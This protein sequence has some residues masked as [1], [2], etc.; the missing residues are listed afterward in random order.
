MANDAHQG[1]DVDRFLARLD[2][3]LKEVVEEVRRL[4]H[5]A[6]DQITERITWNAPSFGYDHQDHV[7]FRL[8][9]REGVQLIFHRGARVKEGDGFSFE[10]GWDLLRWLVRDRA[11]ATLLDRRDVE[12]KGAS[13]TRVVKRWM[14]ATR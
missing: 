9:P 2:H 7:T 10:D 11:A 6:E 12:A 8:Y 3:P 1:N 4:I 14:D 13:L 5:A